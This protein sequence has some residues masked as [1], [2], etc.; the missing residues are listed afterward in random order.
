MARRQW[1]LGEL[2]AGVRAGDARALARAISLVENGDPLAYPLVREL[3]A[4]IVRAGGHPLTR[5]ALDGVAH[6]AHHE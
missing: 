6:R 2:T 5:L 3:Y 1:S 4:R